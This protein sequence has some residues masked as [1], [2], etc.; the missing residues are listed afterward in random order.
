[1]EEARIQREK[2][3]GGGELLREINRDKEKEEKRGAEWGTRQGRTARTEREKRGGGKGGGDG[4]EPRKEK[5]ATH[6]EGEGGKGGRDGEGPRKDK[7]GTH[8]EGEERRRRR[9]VREI[10]RD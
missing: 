6:K 3:G 10:K 4:E 5:G 7:G 2:R 9:I 1:L 8:K